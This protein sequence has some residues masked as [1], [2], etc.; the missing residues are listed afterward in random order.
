MKYVYK[1]IAMLRKYLT[2]LTGFGSLSDL[3]KECTVSS[4]YASWFLAKTIQFIASVAH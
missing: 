1:W 3:L 2:G 4:K